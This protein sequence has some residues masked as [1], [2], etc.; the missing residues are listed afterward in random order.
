MPARRIIAK[1][2]VRSIEPSLSAEPL[3]RFARHDLRADPQYEKQIWIDQVPEFVS[4][5]ARRNLASFIPETADDASPSVMDLS[6][7]DTRYRRPNADFF[8]TAVGS[9]APCSSFD[10]RAGFCGHSGRT[11]RKQGKIDGD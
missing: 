1:R 9:T 6:G 7:S 3:M 2:D 10:W 8:L 4:D 11:S 5:E